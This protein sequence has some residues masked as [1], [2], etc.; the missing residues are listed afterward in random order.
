MRRFFKKWAPYDFFVKQL[1]G[2]DAVVA[3]PDEG[4]R[5]QACDSTLFLA[6]LVSHTVSQT[7]PGT[8]IVCR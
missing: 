2:L 5:R 7:V 6:F 1:G 3:G 4:G 8:V